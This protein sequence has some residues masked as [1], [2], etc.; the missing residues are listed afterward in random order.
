MQFIAGLAL[1]GVVT[2]V[3]NGWLGLFGPDNFYTSAFVWIG[4]MCLIGFIYDRRQARLEE[5]SA[6]NRQ[7]RISHG[8]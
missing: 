8:S 7:D 1:L 5:S 6:E 3:F 4:A 2:W